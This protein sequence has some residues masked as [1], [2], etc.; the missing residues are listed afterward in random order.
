MPNVLAVKGANWKCRN[1]LI[2]SKSLEQTSR[3]IGRAVRRCSRRFDNVNVD[4]AAA[5]RIRQRH[6]DRR[7]DRRRVNMNRFHGNLAALPSVAASAVAYA[8]GKPISNLARRHR[9]DLGKSL[10][11]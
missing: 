8:A 1:A 9:P 5:P 2:K 11:P 6:S 3:E 10:S 4:L 7:C